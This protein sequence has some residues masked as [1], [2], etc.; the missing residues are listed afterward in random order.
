MRLRLR[1]GRSDIGEAL[2]DNVAD[3]AAVMGLRV[4]AEGIEAADQESRSRD[5]GCD[6]GQGFL[7]SRPASFAQY[8]H[9]ADVRRA[10]LTPGGVTTPEPS[11]RSG[12]PGTHGEDGCAPASP[13]A[14]R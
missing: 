9:G 8:R 3:L 11:R 1:H 14:A 6:L 10:A 2:V 4:V 5:V 12:P 7:S 13:R